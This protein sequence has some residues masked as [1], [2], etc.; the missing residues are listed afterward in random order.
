METKIILQ[1]VVRTPQ[2]LMTE[3]LNKELTEWKEEEH[4]KM[5]EQIKTNEL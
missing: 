1:E 2:E 3:Q 4:K 5:L